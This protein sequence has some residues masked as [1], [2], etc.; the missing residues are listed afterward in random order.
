MSPA[1]L[2]PPLTVAA[3][4]AERSDDADYERFDFDDGTV[5]VQGVLDSE[6]RRRLELTHFD[7]GTLID[8]LAVWMPKEFGD[9]S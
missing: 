6:D 8:G 4:C 7:T 3:M 1:L 5:R 2:P 9:D